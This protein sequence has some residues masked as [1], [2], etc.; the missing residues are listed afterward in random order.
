LDSATVN[1]LLKLLPEDER[2][3]LKYVAVCLED[4]LAGEVDRDSLVAALEVFGQIRDSG[5]SPKDILRE[6]HEKSA[7]VA[8]VVRARNLAP[9]NGGAGRAAPPRKA[10]GKAKR[11]GSRKEVGLAGR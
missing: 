8:P 7:K 5:V 1:G 10:V 9:P 3:G 11:N 6:L 2:Y 4:G